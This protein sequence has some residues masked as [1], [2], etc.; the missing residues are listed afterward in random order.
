MIRKTSPLTLAC[1]LFI[2]IL[3]G[4]GYLKDDASPQPL[5]PAQ[6]VAAAKANLAIGF[7]SGD[8][9]SAVTHDLTLPLVGTS[10]TTITWSSSNPAVVSAAGV[11]HRLA[12]SDASVI[13]TATITKDGV[14]DTET[15]SIIVK[16]QM[17][18][19]QAVA[20]AKSTVEVGVAPSDTGSSV[21]QDLTLPTTGSNGST[22]TWSSSDPSL[23][24]PAG[25]V[26]QPLV[27]EASV[28][29]TATI[30][31]GGTTDTKTFT[32]V[33]KGQMTEADA[34]AAA[35]A[36]LAVE[37]AHGDSASAVTQDLGLPSSGMYDSVVAWS[38]SNPAVVS[39]EGSVHRPTDSDANVTLTATITIGS[40]SD[41]KLFP[42]TVKFRISEAQAIVNAAKA[43]LAIEFAP[44]EDASNVTKNLTLP[45][46]L[47]HATI[48][49]QSSDPA[50]ITAAGAVT[51]PQ[52]ADAN[53]TLTATITSGSASDTKQ[54]PIVVKQMSEAAARVAMAKANL[55]VGFF[56]GDD[57]S[58]VTHNVTLLTTLHGTSITWA[59]S[60]P[61]VIGTTGAVTRPVAS[62]ESVTLTATITAGSDSDTKP[63]LLTVKASTDAQAVA[64]AKAALT[65]EFGPGDDASSVTRDLTLPTVLDQTTI[66]W[67]SSDPSAISNA[68][69]VT[70]PFT[71]G[72]NVTLTATIAAGSVND[73]KSFPLFVKPR[74]AT[75]ADFVAAIKEDLEIEFAK[76]DDSSHVTE[77]LTLAEDAAIAWSSSDPDIIDATG[78]V[79]QP[80]TGDAN[81]TITATITVGSASDTKQFP[82]VVKAQMTDDD[83]VN[84]AKDDLAIGYA[85]G[86]ADSTVTQD[87]KLPSTGLYN[88]TV[89][90]SSSDPAVGSNGKVS[91]PLTTD[92]PVTL[93]ATVNLRAASDTKD[94]IVLV[95][96][97]M[98]DA[99]AVA[100]AKAALAIGYRAGDN[101]T[102][103]TQNLT[104]PLT[105]SNACTVSWASSDPSLIDDSGVVTQPATGD[106]SVT[107]TAT[108]TSHA[109][110]D[111]A[112]F[113]LTVKGQVTDADAVAAAKAAL[114]ITYGSGDDASNVTQNLT[115]PANST[116]ATTITWSSS[117]PSVISDT[118]VVTQPVGSDAAVTL[119]ATITS[120]ATSDTL[121]FALTV[122]AIMDDA[123][124]VAAD[125]AAILIGF[126]PGDSDTNVTR[127]LVLPTSG[128]NGS[129]ITW[130]TDDPDT[131]TASGGVTVPSDSDKLVTLTAT[132]GRGIKSDTRAFPF[133]VK[134]LLL[135]T[136]VNSNTI[137]PGN[138]A[139][140]V[141]PGIVIAIPFTRPLEPST[142]DDSTFQLVKTSNAQ[143]VAITVTYNGPSQTVE[144]IPQSPLEQGTQ[145]TTLISTS[146]KDSGANNLPSPMG[147]N[148]TTLSYASI[149][150][151]WKFNGDGNDSSGHANALNLVDGS[152]DVLTHEGSGSL[153]L[154]GTAQY[155]ESNINLG[156]QL[157]V[158]VWVNVDNP[159]QDSINTLMSNAGPGEQSNGFKLGING[160]GTSDESVVI[161]VGNGTTGGKWVTSTGLIQP[162]N[163]YHL[164]FVID[165][166]N[167]TMKIYYN[168][169]EAP[170]AFHSDQGFVVGQFAYNFKTT[171]PFTIGSFPNGVNYSF[172]GH[173]D[174]MRV[175]N[176]VLAAW[177]IAKIA[178]EK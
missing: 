99:Q 164:A 170:L 23:V 174:D 109:E 108:I 63:F 146:L 49:W 112:S 42:V 138:G 61:A 71:G 56:L 94:F 98:T 165:Q 3:S 172:K 20:E 162:G 139:I 1:L 111:T 173:L 31:V 103:V 117:D 93:T 24:S 148:F 48:T 156:T 107:L 83:A 34:V 19:A 124:A 85:P 113:T 44:G 53:V 130:A 100:A 18:E 47:N 37:F 25:V 69:E 8:S 30:T 129:D 29:L 80:V 176:R 114:N 10:D 15:F 13:L 81:V 28:T 26:H 66:T 89:S 171:G 178:Q 159:I 115:L 39:N 51:Q 9:L 147:F 142:V 163:W 2:T 91:Q 126:G 54:F 12:T 58:S 65:I 102:N 6:I 155:G 151:Q 75:D 120:H 101:S 40:A 27:G 55:A 59:S 97:Q 92:V 5:T 22:V 77:N 17:T 21:T 158:A 154:N 167:S 52:N 62:D 105:G 74:F 90:W 110:S 36:A 38:S 145:Y 143:P 64:A 149:L 160:W 106:A 104:L 32:V 157:T 144:L 122:K 118:G 131:I 70:R 88:T 87:V 116:N 73:T 45:T 135:S 95:K 67:Q 79:T 57:A 137:S 166:P 11:V 35:K 125:K 121:D 72:A 133:T 76:H 127:N 150:S 16:A 136:W 60:D 4:C 119:T 41:T 132:I 96:A 84:A 50:V 153:Y 134:A 140:E 46:S 123:S 175:Y 141:D 169:A 177:E 152:F 14:S 168:G 33:V 43:A 7:A 128:T 82:L 161:E 68:G 86:D 78:V